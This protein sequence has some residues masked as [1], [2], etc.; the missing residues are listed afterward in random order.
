MLI[1]IACFQIV[2]KREMVFC[3]YSYA[4]KKTKLCSD[5]AQS[6]NSSE[7]FSSCRSIRRVCEDDVKML[8]FIRRLTY[9]SITSLNRH[10]MV[11]RLY[12]D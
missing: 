4:A 9:Y 3:R 7:P 5:I 12:A 6:Y 1:F 10:L 11:P 8:S 2:Q